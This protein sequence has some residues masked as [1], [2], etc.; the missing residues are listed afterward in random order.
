MIYFFSWGMET[1]PGPLQ[2]PNAGGVGIGQAGRLRDI[3]RCARA[4]LLLARSTKK[5][6]QGCSARIAARDVVASEERELIDSKAVQKT[7][8]GTW[9]RT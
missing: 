6:L 7:R 4:G 8:R 5:R 1:L 3:A 9:Q 2:S